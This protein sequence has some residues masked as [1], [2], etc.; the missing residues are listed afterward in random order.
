MISLSDNNQKTDLFNDVKGVKVSYHK[1]PNPF[2]TLKHCL[3][4]HLIT[5]HLNHT[6]VLKEQLLNAHLRGDCFSHGDICLTPAN[7]PVLVVS[8][9]TYPI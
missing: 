4:Q 3:S 1:Y 5:I 9:L 7:I 8:P 2:E 6:A